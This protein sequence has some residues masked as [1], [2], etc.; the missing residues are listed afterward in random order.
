MAAK[1]EEMKTLYETYLPEIT[2][3]TEEW[4]DFLSLSGRNYKLPF[5]EQFMTF[6]QRPDAVA[7][8]EIAKQQFCVYVYF[9]SCSLSLA[10]CSFFSHHPIKEGF[11]IA[12]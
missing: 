11:R 12:V 10:L 3:S 9:F 6:A 4:T 7:V 8:L 5:E 1:Y 2:S